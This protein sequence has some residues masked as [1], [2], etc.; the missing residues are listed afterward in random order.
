MSIQEVQ[1]RKNGRSEI[2]NAMNITIQLYLKHYRGSL[3]C[4]EPDCNAKMSF[5]ERRKN[6]TKY[7][8]TWSKSKHKKDCPFEV[9]YSDEGYSKFKVGEEFNINLTDSHI[10]EK[11]KRAY[12]AIIK[13]VIR[14]TQ[15]L[16]K[17]PI[18]TPN[19]K[20]K[21]KIVPALFS[22]GIDQT[23]KKRP[24]ILT[25]R[26]DK[27]DQEDFGEVRCIV[28]TVT[29]IQLQ[30]NHAYINFTRKGPNSV[31]VCFTESFVREN[32]TQFNNFE[33]LQTYC[34]KKINNSE[35]VICCC[36]GKVRRVDTGINIYPD[37]YKS[38][39]LN[40]LGFY[41]ILKEINDF[42]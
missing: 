29:T 18:K 38:F 25:R 41:D 17:N 11:L 33:V 32:A 1:C 5:V 42:V 6:N 21:D 30:P 39:T 35:F 26:F 34:N 31:K 12:E 28:G 23:N 37:R 15:S 9:I 10:E 4:I 8:R 13:N 19:N 2:I 40:G 36:I 14:G 3:F 24:Y 7:F 22:E 27:L 20:L 16:K